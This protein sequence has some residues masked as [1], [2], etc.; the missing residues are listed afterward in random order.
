MCAST[1]E[2][3]RIFFRESC[4]S[5]TW[6]SELIILNIFIIFQMISLLLL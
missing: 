5:I 1:I 4:L 6:Y 3:T 2:F